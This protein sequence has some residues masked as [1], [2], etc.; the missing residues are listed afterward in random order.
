MNCFRHPEV[1]AVGNCKACSKGLCVACAIDIG[2]GLACRDTCETEVRELNEMTERSKKIY[3]IGRYKSRIPSS[4]VLIWSL[5]SVGM[6]AATGAVYFT[7]GKVEWTSLTM[8]VI[9]TIVLGIALYSSRR[10]GLNC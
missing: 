8:A 9:F 3:G 1:I 7:R 10:T 4:G 6:W 2:T 5:F